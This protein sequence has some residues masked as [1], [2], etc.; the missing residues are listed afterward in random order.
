M[1]KD[2]GC[3]YSPD[4]RIQKPDFL[5]KAFVSG[6][7]SRLIRSMCLTEFLQQPIDNNLTISTFLARESIAKNDVNA[8]SVYVLHVD[9]ASPTSLHLVGK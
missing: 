4:S 3:E 9:T 8:H 6:I 2:S 5:E 7:N 1:K